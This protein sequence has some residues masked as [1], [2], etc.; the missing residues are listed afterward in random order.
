MIF[1]FSQAQSFK[2]PLFS[3]N[4]H[5]EEPTN[6]NKNSV[7]SINNVNIN[8]LRIDLTKTNYFCLQFLGFT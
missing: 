7:S 3:D 5:L 4:R 6:I 8:L 2:S 1:I